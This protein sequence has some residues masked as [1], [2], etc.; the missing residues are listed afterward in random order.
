MINNLFSLH[1]YLMV[2]IAIAISYILAYLFIRLPFVQKRWPLQQQLRFARFCFLLAIITFLVMPFLVTSLSIQHSNLEFK[3]AIHHASMS[4]LRHHES[5]AAEISSSQP[6][7]LPFSFNTVLLIAWI[8]GFIFYAIK[9]LL[10]FTRL[11]QLKKQAFCQHSFPFIR[12]LY[13]DQVNS[14]FCWSLLR[15]CFIVIPYALLEKRNEMRLVIRH[16]LQHLRQGDTHW[17]KFMI[18]IKLLCFWN[19]FV[20]LWMHWL[21]ELQEFACDEAVILRNQTP[22]AT[23]AQCLINTARD[24]IHSKTITPGI[25]AINGLSTSL[26]YRRVN[27]LFH[28]KKQKAKLALILAYSFSV[29]T[30]ASAAYALNGSGSAVPLSAREISSII[31]EVDLQNDLRIKPTPALIKAI[32]AI[33]GNEKTKQSLQ[34]GLERMKAYQPYIQSEL[35]KRKMPNDLLAIPLVESRYKALVESQNPMKAAGIWQIIPSTAKNFGLTVTASRD[36]RLDTKRSTQAA[37]DYL[38][39]LYEQFHDWRLAI[40]AY[41]IGERETARL[42]NVTGSRD[43]WV[44]ANATQHK[45]EVSDYLAMTEAAILII[46]QPSLI[47]A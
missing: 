3:P 29:T 7:S 9:L 4:F 16:E 44:L 47:N 24:T 41:E 28:Y 12:I 32:N 8:G 14:P 15:Q 40:L 38:G 17:L 37:L 21:N 31:Q 13:S 6:L 27:M 33:R 36:D 22:P 20:F 46:H 23:Y 18:V 35:G 39:S 25:L 45:K 26:L 34:A 11:Q 30:L 1:T 5:I 43:V 10:A 19:P 42:I 2:N